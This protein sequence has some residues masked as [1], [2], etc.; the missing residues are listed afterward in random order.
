[1]MPPMLAPDMGPIGMPSAL[2]DLQHAD[3]GQP[4]RTAPAEREPDALGFAS[5]IRHLGTPVPGRA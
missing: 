2:E 5:F 1:M 3:V 4:T